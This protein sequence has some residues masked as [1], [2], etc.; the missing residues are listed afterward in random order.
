MYLSS[1]WHSHTQKYNHSFRSR[2]CS[3]GFCLNKNI[4][5]FSMVLKCSKLNSFEHVEETGTSICSK[6]YVH[7][8]TLYN[9]HL[10]ECTTWWK[11]LFS[12]LD[13]NL[14][15]EV[16]AHMGWLSLNCQS[17]ETCSALIRPCWVLELTTHQSEKADDVHRS[18]QYTE[19]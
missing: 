8:H 17:G 9:A 6:L 13:L 19:T 1:N 18:H 15:A 5:V 14:S 11:G 16:I 10:M 12:I 3:K 2:N 7:V 4:P